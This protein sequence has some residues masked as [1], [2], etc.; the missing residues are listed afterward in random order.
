M[1][2]TGHP[3]ERLPNSASL[4]IDGVEGG[5]LVAALDLDGIAGSTGSACTSGAS[6]PSHVLLAMG[7]DPQRAHGSLRLTAGRSTTEVEVD[8]AIEVIGAVIGR[9]RGAVVP[10]D[11]VASA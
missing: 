7:F 8:R 4:L 9:M 5:D 1:E 3:V 11:A 6:D 2:A 10:R